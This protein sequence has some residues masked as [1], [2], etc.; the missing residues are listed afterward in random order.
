MAVASAPVMVT[1]V[2]QATDATAALI[3]MRWSPAAETVPPISEGFPSMMSPSSVQQGGSIPA[4]AH[5]IRLTDGK[6]DREEQK[7]E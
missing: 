7:E 3:A 4:V 1:G 6:R 2:S 5:L